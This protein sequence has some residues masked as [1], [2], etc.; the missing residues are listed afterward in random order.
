MLWYV[1]YTKPKSEK[2]VSK[3]LEAANIENYCPT[4]VEVKQWSDRLKKVEVPLFKS[5]VFVRIHEKDRE[6]VFQ[7]PGTLRYLYWLGKPAV[8]K[9]K[10]IQTIKDWLNDDSYDEFK[11]EGLAPGQ[12]VRIK[13]GAFQNQDGIVKHIGSKRLSLI[14]DSIGCIVSIKLKEIA[15]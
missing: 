12:R 7:F 9:D 8:V 5:Y 14:L 4:T 11:I 3:Y 2:K 13:E 6:K 1:I 15:I 10:E